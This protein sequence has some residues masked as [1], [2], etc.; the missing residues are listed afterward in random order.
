MV[1]RLGKI[2]WKQRLTNEVVLAKL[3]TQRSLMQTIKSRKMKFFGHT[4]RHDSIMKTILEGKAEGTRPQGR[5]R[6]Q[7]CDNIKQWTGRSLA[8]CTRMT[9]DRDLWRRASSQP[10]GRDGTLK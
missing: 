3:N 9:E 7:W 8:D 4:K 6:A 1:R 10:L 5:P 2:S